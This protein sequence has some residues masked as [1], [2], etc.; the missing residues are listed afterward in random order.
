MTTATDKESNALTT[1]GLGDLEHAVTDPPA[2]LS[3]ALSV[4]REEGFVDVD[5]VKIHY[6]RW[7]DP[8]KPGILM[9]HGFLAHARCFAF[10]A[11]YLAADYHVVAYDLSGMGDSDT[12]ESYPDD[13]R[14][15]ELMSVTEQTGLFEHDTR[16]TIIAHSYGGHVGLAAVHAHPDRFAGIM[17]C[18]LM[19]LRP[20]FLEAHSNLFKSPGNQDPDRPNRIYPDFATAKGRYVL[21]PPQEVEEQV[22]FDYMAYHSLKQVEGGWSWKFDPSV[23][24]RDSNLGQKWL[25]TCDKMVTAP[26]RKVIIHGRESL[27]FNAD[28]VDYV[29]ETIAEHN[30]TDFPIIGIPH[31]RHHLMLD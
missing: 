8:S 28:S 16:P 12:R 23:F 13:V 10:I 5:G 3:E 9:L 24:R 1:T 21:S 22:L 19:I 27:L 18:D 11:P 17:V 31:A 2:W 30:A 26:G 25:Q 4:P 14:V 6:F 29:R 20:S 15:H 7:G